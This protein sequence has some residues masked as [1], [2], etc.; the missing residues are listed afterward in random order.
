MTDA[1]KIRSIEL[2]IIEAER[3][4]QDKAYCAIY[5][6][7]AAGIPQDIAMARRQIDRLKGN[8]ISPND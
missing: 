1:A 3:A 5:P 2:F 6:D 4:Q 8:E 7:L